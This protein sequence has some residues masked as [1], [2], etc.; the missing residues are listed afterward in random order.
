MLGTLQVFRAKCIPTGS[1]AISS[2]HDYITF[3]DF[4]FYHMRIALWQ[5]DLSPFPISVERA[6]CTGYDCEGRGTVICA[7]TTETNQGSVLTVGS[8]PLT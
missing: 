2:E 8:K 1:T 3:F 4:P 7:R 5:P 6:H